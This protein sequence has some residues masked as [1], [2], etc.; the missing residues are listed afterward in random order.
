MTRTIDGLITTTEYA[1]GSAT[2]SGW[3]VVV[4]ETVLAG[5]VIAAQLPALKHGYTR[6]TLRWVNTQTDD[7]S[8]CEF[9]VRDEMQT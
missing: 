7:E 4:Q 5:D 2:H 9:E 6:R 3:C 8:R 1:D